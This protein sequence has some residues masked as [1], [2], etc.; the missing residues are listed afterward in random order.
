MP[1]DNRGRQSHNKLPDSQESTGSMSHMIQHL[2]VAADR[3]GL[4]RL[5]QLCEAKL[6][7]ELNVD[8]VA[9]T[10]FLAHDH[11]CSQLKAFCMDFAV[12][13]LRELVPKIAELLLKITAET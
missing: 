6:C 12:D 13:N 10:L 1:E 4:D 5:K 7:K 11:H 8:V 3:F 9:T 2:L